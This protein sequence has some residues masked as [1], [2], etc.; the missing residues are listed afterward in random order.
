MGTGFGDIFA[1][2]NSHQKATLAK[3]NFNNKVVRM[4]Y[5]VDMSVT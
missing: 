1:H 4:T 5:S 3:G 2:E